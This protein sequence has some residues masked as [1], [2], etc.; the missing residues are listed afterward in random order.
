MCISNF[1]ACATIAQCFYISYIFYKEN[2]TCNFED[3]NNSMRCI[4]KSSNSD[5]WKQI[6]K[7]TNKQKKIKRTNKQITE[8]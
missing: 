8:I 1:S 3:G 4:Q 6:K 5:T 7:Q 2:H